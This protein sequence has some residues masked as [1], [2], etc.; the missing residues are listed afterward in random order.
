M[1][2]LQNIFLKVLSACKNISVYMKPSYAAGIGIID[3]ST[4]SW[5]TIVVLYYMTRGFNV[6]E[7][8]FELF[9]VT[10]ACIW[11]SLQQIKAG[12][13]E[14]FG[15]KSSHFMCLFFLN[16]EGRPLTAAEISELSSL[17]KAAVSRNIAK[18][19]ESGYVTY[20]KPDEERKYRAKIILTDEG[21]R[22]S[23]TISETI[24]EFV[25]N[26]SSGISDEDRAVFYKCLLTISSNL[27]N[28]SEN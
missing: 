3:G 7:E 25:N 6:L 8:R 10:I 2:I 16:H 15:L 11:R 13:M 1:T 22:L 21:E 5:Y 24:D 9:T 26:A 27:Q 14:P 19:Q 4:K 20:E 18:L 17:D 23:V 28:I 12:I